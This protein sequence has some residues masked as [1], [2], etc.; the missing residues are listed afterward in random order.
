MPTGGT[1]FAG[2]S[3]Y[4]AMAKRRWILIASVALLATGYTINSARHERVQ[5]RS[6]ATVR[7]VD[8]SRAISGNIADPI[9]TQMPFSNRADPIASQ[10]Q[11]LTSEAVATTA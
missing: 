2:L 3:E 9:Q 10:Q 6:K 5:Y 1:E 4:V 8:P 7:L 11:I